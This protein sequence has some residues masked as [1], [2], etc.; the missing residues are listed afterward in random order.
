MCGWPKITKQESCA[1]AGRTA[2]RL[3]KFRYVS[4]FTTSR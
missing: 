4:N 3:S 1:I 2:R